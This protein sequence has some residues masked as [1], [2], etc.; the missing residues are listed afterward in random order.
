M[1][2]NITDLWHIKLYSSVDEIIE[3]ISASM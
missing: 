2:T 1:Y 3:N